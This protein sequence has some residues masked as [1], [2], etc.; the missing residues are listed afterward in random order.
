MNSKDRDK[1]K[2][3]FGTV[4]K[5]PGDKAGKIRMQKKTS[6]CITLLLRSN[7]KLR[8]KNTTLEENAVFGYIPNVNS[9]KGRENAEES[10][11][12]RN[13]REDVQGVNEGDLSDALLQSAGL[14]F[15]WFM[16]SRS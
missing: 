1:R 9:G 13:V 15:S 8:R 6:R 2:T 5:G 14:G 3:M 4:V 10:A 7:T 12:R 16:L 11:C